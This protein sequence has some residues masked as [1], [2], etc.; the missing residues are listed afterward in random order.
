MIGYLK[1]IIK[2][3]D[4]NNLILDVNKVGYLLFVPF[5]VLEKCYLGEEK[6]FFV[7]THVRE[8]EISL[9]GF[10]KLEDKNVFLQ[11]ISVSGVGPKTA[12]NI[13]SY[14]NGTV[15]IIKAIK[16]A[17]VDFFT[18]IKGIGKKTSQRIIVDLKSKIGGIKELDFTTEED[19]D[20]IEALQGLGFS[21]KEVKK[22]IKDIGK[23]FSLEEKVKQALKNQN[24]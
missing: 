22:V 13:I 21:N 10:T 5:F 24:G 20:L 1:G 7:Y 4:I 15:N 18:E 17:D 8:S 16:N 12:L 19:K 9:Y 6:E 23:D 3:K 14:G 11:L 2:N